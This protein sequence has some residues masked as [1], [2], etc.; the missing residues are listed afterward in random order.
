MCFHREIYDEEND[1]K[2]FEEIKNESIRL[3]NH[4]LVNEIDDL[5]DYWNIRILTSDIGTLRLFERKFKGRNI[6]II[7]RDP[8]MFPDKSPYSVTQ[9]I[10]INKRKRM[11]CSGVRRFLFY[12]IFLIQLFIVGLI[13]YLYYHTL[14]LTQN[15]EL[16]MLYRNEIWFSL[17]NY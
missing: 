5:G 17:F 12:L 1:L 8:T 6:E 16:F 9:Y 11:N 15:F 3:E 7:K 10:R 13:L 2:K 14:T 4:V